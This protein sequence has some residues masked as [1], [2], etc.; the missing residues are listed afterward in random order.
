MPLK[1][2]R[3]GLHTQREPVVVMRT[4]CP[5][6]HS[7]GLAARS[8]VLLRAGKREVTAV[9]FQQDD[10]QL[11]LDEVGLSEAAWKLLAARRRAGRS[12][13]CSPVAFHAVGAPPDIR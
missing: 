6:C 12:D 13:P 11:K 4:D 7:E 2:R 3:I 10:A 1:A 8:Q 9:L 5:V